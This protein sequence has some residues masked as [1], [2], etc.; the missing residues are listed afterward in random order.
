MGM[1]K[2]VIGVYEFQVP[3]RVADILRQIA[4]KADR[5][6]EGSKVL[7]V[8]LRGPKVTMTVEEEL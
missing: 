8:A 3:R 6:A 4:E 5:L 2:V 1:V 7:R